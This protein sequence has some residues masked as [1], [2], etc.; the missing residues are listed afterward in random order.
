[1][2]TA[3]A[4]FAVAFASFGRLPVARRLARLTPVPAGATVPAGTPTA[5]AAR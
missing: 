3:R 2:R 5:G 4:E 1:M